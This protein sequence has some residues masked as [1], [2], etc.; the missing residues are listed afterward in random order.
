MQGNRKYI[1]TKNYNNSQPSIQDTLKIPDTEVG[2]VD[3]E[4]AEMNVNEKKL[5]TAM[6][7]YEMDT[8]RRFPIEEGEVLKSLG[9]SGDINPETG[10]TRY[11]QDLASS[12]GNIASAGKFVAGTAKAGGFLAGAGGSIAAVA[13]PAAIIAGIASVWKGANDAAA[14]NRAKMKE[15]GKGIDKINAKR[16]QLGDR[17]REDIANIWEGVGSKLSDIRYGI[18]EKFEDVSKTVG[19]VIQR[20]KGLATGDAEQIVGKA[21]TNV[22]DSLTRQTENLEDVAGE[23]IDQYG[24]MMEDE[25]ESMTMEI[26]DMQD[27]IGELDKRSQGW[28]NILT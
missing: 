3:N 27:E 25:T 10:R 6:R 24:R 13:G 2:M 1:D 17:A 22:Q 28:Q 8:G 16:V 19:G 11:Q 9:G 5:V 14:A 12:L 23:K 4:I 15:L 7:A 21:T 20:G 18:G 26:A